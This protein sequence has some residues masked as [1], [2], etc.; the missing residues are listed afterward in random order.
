M[1]KIKKII[2][3]YS[4]L[5]T[6]VYSCDCFFDRVNS[7]IDTSLNFTK[8]NE[9]ID[10]LE[11]EYDVKKYLILFFGGKIVLI[12][13]LLLNFILKIKKEDEKIHLTHCVTD[14][15][16]SNDQ[17]MEICTVCFIKILAENKFLKRFVTEKKVIDETYYLYL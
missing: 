12:C 8:T 15:I 9:F 2:I 11:E 3:V 14:F 17:I 10:I 6:E 1:I 4:H 7:L 5:V 13:K 16:E